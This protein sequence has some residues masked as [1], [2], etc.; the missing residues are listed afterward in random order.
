MRKRRTQ[1]MKSLLLAEHLQVRK[2][3]WACL[4]RDFFFCS[5]FWGGM[6][7]CINIPNGMNGPQTLYL[8]AN[9]QCCIILH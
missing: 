9:T 7:E 3:Y 5:L 2:N 4:L 6:F 8:S 1:L